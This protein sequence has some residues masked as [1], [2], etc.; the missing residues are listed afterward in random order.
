MYAVHQINEYS[1]VL[2]CIES[3]LHDQG[4][5]VSQQQLMDRYQAECQIGSNSPGCVQ[6]ENIPALLQHVGLR[7][8]Q[9]LTTS[10]NEEYFL[11]TTKPSYH[12][13]RYRGE[14]VNGEAVIMDPVLVQRDIELNCVLRSPDSIHKSNPIIYRIDRI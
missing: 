11:L 1:C 9:V 8:T 2:A 14:A 5:N 4:E 7:P 12:C 3:L 10:T 13:I 6:I